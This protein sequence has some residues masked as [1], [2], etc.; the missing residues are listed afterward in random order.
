MIL[1]DWVS[2][3]SKIHTP[4]EIIDLLG[5][6]ECNW[7]SLHGA[8]GYMERL[9]YDSISIHY[10]GRADMGVW[11]EMS[12]QGCRA[13]EEFG[14]GDYNVLFTLVRDNPQTMHITRLDVAFDEYTGILDINTLCKHTRLNKYRS[15]MQYREIHD[16]TNGLSL[17][18]GSNSSDVLIRIY[19]K[20]AERLSHF[21]NENE[22]EKIKDEIS[23]WIRVELQMR[24]DRA[25]E[26]L[27]YLLPQGKD[28]SIGQAYTGVL[29][30]Y[31]EYG[32]WREHK[33]GTQKFCRFS[34]WEKVLAGAEALSI[35][36]KPGTDYNLSRLIDYTINQAGNATDTAI[37]ILGIETYLKL[38]EKRQTQQ[39]PKYINL[40]SKYQNKGC[41]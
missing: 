39:N 28:M 3:T 26:F 16:S 9:Y 19:D 34:Y 30:N 17:Q 37:K 8:H 12:G 36:V 6:S 33:D 25:R 1:I 32:Y 14:I 20:L 10:A 11:L 23:H 15:K 31:L 35:Y 2:I 13:F 7:Q 27:N 5:M 29:K 18:I 24:D 41:L 22:K 38:L 40:L 4:E 21:R